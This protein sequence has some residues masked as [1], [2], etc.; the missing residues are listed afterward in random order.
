MQESKKKKSTHTGPGQ[1]RSPQIH[2]QSH[3]QVNNSYT[4]ET[5]EIEKG[6]SFFLCSFV[7][8]YSVWGR[9]CL[10]EIRGSDKSSARGSDKSSRS[11]EALVLG[12]CEEEELE[13]AGEG[14][15]VLITSLL[16]GNRKNA[17][18]Y[19]RGAFLVCQV[20]DGVRTN[21]DSM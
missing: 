17:Y 8:L 5:L 13:A 20:L 6:L 14:T 18:C 2:G 4:L 19:L 9:P 15:R 3:R 1:V 21:S 16:L 12:C 11:R 10:W 7:F